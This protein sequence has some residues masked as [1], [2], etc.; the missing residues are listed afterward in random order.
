[1]EHCVFCSTLST[2][3]DFRDCGRPCETHAV[4]L[5]DH[6]GHSHPLLP[7]A[8]CRNTMFNAEPQSAAHYVPQML[9]AGIRHFRIE[10]LRERGIDAIGDLI[11]QYRDVIAGRIEPKRAIRSLRVV[12]QLGV[13][14]GTLER[15]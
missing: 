2:G 5:R 6:L 10:L 15:E 11:R 13:T 12:S 8:G 4:E 14:A 9:R 7:D 3:K 1:M